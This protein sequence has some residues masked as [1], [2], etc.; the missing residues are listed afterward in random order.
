MNSENRQ[1]PDLHGLFTGIVLIVAGALFLLDRMDYLEFHDVAHR[2]WPMFLV[3]LGVL[4]LTSGRRPWSGIW[5][6]IIGC[7][8]QATTL[9]L[10]GLTFDTSWPL[11]LIG[12]GAT[13]VLRTLLLGVPHSEAR[14]D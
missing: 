13:M 3:L 2:Y 1:H 7:W 14:H 9:H 8:L 12:I 10:W 4:K 5:L 11:L 6:I